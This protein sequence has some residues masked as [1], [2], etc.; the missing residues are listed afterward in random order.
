MVFESI[1]VDLL[2]RFVGEY[3]ENLDSKQLKIGIWGGDVVLENLVMKQSALDDLNLPVKTV[4]GHLGKLILKIPWKNL[5]SSPTEA[6]V[7]KLFLLVVPNQDTRYD[8]VKEEKWKQEAKQAEIEKVEAAKKKELE[9]DK[10]KADDTFTEKMITQ[11]VRNV[12]ICIKDIH[13]RYE[14]RV[15]SPKSPFSFGITLH[16]LS[17]TTTNEDWIP[18]ISQDVTGKIFKHLTIDGLAIYWNSNCELFSLIQSQGLNNK[19]QSGI[20]SKGQLVPGY[21]YMVGP[22]SC[23]AKLQL[24][25]KPELDDFQV[26]KS[27]FNIEMEKV[28]LKISKLQYRDIFALVDSLDRMRRAALYRKYRPQ[29]NTFRGHYKL[30]WQYAY[31]CIL[32][33][34]VRRRRRNWDWVHIFTHRANCRK[35]AEA[36]Q[37]KLI[38]ANKESD[39]TCKECEL[40]LDA[41]NIVLIRQKI[42]VEVERQGKL[43]EAKKKSE[44]AKGWFSGWWGGGSSESV[45]ED[46]SKTDDIKKQ[47]AEAMS[48]EEKEKLF[49]AIGYQENFVP[50]DLP[51]EFVAVRLNF[52]LQCLEVE[53]RDDDLQDEKSV[54]RVALN[55]ME[56]QLEQRPSANAI[57]VT[58][59]MYNLSA[60]GLKQLDG[61]PEVCSS[62]H[63]IEG[64]GK[65]PLV[66]IIFE[67][68]PLCGTCD[69]RVHAEFKPLQIVYDAQTIIKLT[70]IFTPQEEQSAVVSQLQAA[71]QM[72]MAE[73]KEKSALGLQ[74]TIQKHTRL[75]LKIDVMAS[76]VIIP[77]GGFY[78]KKQPILV[79]NLGKFSVSS[80]LRQEDPLNV[81]NMHKEGYSEDKILDIL[82]A[83]S[84]DHFVLKLEAAQVL[85]AYPDEDWLSL[86]CN[87]KQSDLHLLNPTDLTIEIEKCLISDDP[88]LPKVKIK[89][90]LP[91]ITLRIKEKRMVDTLV[92]LM[93]IPF[94]EAKPPKSHDQDQGIQ[95]YQSTLSITPHD[96]NR[97][98]K[99]KTVSMQVE[100]EEIIQY[101]DVE[102]N[103]ELQQIF[104]EM[105][106]EKGALS[107]NPTVSM[108]VL[109]LEA[110]LLVQTF[111][112]SAEARLGGLELLHNFESKVIKVIDTPMA[113]G[114]NEDLLILNY[115]SADKDSP[116]FH[117]RYGSILQY[118]TVHFS[119]LN[120]LV[121]QEALMFLIHWIGNTQSYIEEQ[122]KALGTKTLEARPNTLTVKKENFRSSLTNL[123]ESMR[124][125]F[126]P[127]ASRVI[128]KK[129]KAKR[130]EVIDL[131]LDAKLDEIGI[132][133]SNNMHDLARLEVSGCNSSII[134]KKSYTQI[135]GKLTNFQVFDFNKDTAHP[136][137]LTI[138]GKEE[139][140][141]AQLVLFNEELL[142]RTTD[143][144]NMSVRA[145]IGCVRIVFINRFL[146][147]VIGFMNNF[148]T[149]QEKLREASAA[150]AEAARSNVR[151]AYS[152]AVKIRL[153][154]N[155]K[156]PIIVIP[157]NSKSFNAMF[158][159]FGF[160]TISNNFQDIVTK[161]DG[162]TA[163]IDHIS[164]NLVNLKASRVLLDDQGTIKTEQNILKPIT[165]DLGVQRNLSCGWYTDV[166]DLDVG[167]RLGT[168]LIQLTQNDYVTLMSI[169]S[170]NLAE[171]DSSYTKPNEHPH[172]QPQEHPQEHISSVATVSSNVPMSKSSTSTKAL[173]QSL[174][175]GSGP[176]IPQSD[177]TTSIKFNFRLESIV[178][179]LFTDD[180]ETED[181]RRN[182]V[183]SQSL[184]R[185]TLHLL[186]VKG[187]M[188]SD[189]T[190]AS[191]VLML[192]LLL[193][194]TRASKASKINRYMERVAQD[195][196]SNE[197]KS[198]ESQIESDSLFV[199]S[200][201]TFQVD[202]RQRESS[203]TPAHRRAMVDATIR[204][205]DGNLYLDLRVYSFLLILNLEHL[206]K[207]RDLFVL[208]EKPEVFDVAKKLSNQTKLHA[209]SV[210]SYVAKVE[211]QTAQVGVEN[212]EI[213]RN[214]DIH[215]EKPDII[216]VENL[217]DVNTNALNLQ[218]EMNAKLS[219]SG[220]G[221]HQSISANIMDLQ[222]FTCC[223]NP[224][225]RQNTKSLVLFP[226]C[227]SLVGTTPEDNGLHL[228]LSTTR[229]HLSVSPGTIE[230]LNKCYQ[231]LYDEGGNSKSNRNDSDYS[232]VWN[233]SRVEEKDFWFLSSEVAQDALEVLAIES[234]VEAVEP[235]NEVCSVCVPSLVITLDTGIGKHTVPCL[236]LESTASGKV[237]NWSSNLSVNME[238]TLQIDYYNY[239]LA[240][241][242]PVLEPIETFN[243]GDRVL[244]PWK[245]NMEMKKLAVEDVQQQC[246]DDTEGKPPAMTINIKSLEAMELTITKTCLDVLSN[247][248]ASFQDAIYKPETIE[249]FEIKAPYLIQNDTGLSISVV[250]AN[251]A[252]RVSGVENTESI[253]EVVLKPD[254]SV[255]LSAL[256]LTGNE[257]V[258]R[259]SF[260]GNKETG[261]SSGRKRSP[262]LQTSFVNRM[263]IR[264]IDERFL[265]LNIEEMNG[266][267]QIPMMKCDKRYFTLHKPNSPDTV[268]SKSISSE[269]IGLVV[270]ITLESNATM[271][272][273]LCSIIRIYN[274]FSVAI[275]VYF[276]TKKGNEVQLIT[277]IPPKSHFNLPV[278][279]IYTPAKE[280]FFSVEGYSLSTNPFIWKEVQS[281]WKFSKLLQCNSKNSEDK[282][283]FFIKAV[284]E[285]EQ[286]YFEHGNRH[287]M[288]SNCININLNPPVVL[289]NLLPVDIIC[290]VQGIVAENSIKS[291]GLFEIPT[292]EPGS[293][294]I[295]L[296]ISGYLDREWSC[297][298]SI[299]E[300][301]P[302]LDVWI[303]ECYES[304]Q[305]IC[306]ELGMHSVI[307]NGC[308]VMQLYCPFW[309]INKTG[310]SL[311]YRRSGKPT[312][313]TVS[314]GIPTEQPDDMSNVLFHPDNFKG[315]VMFS[316]RAKNFFGKKKAT[317]KVENGEWSEKF[318][319]D[320]V[321]SYGVVSCV[322]NSIKYQIGVNIQ[323]MSNS[324]TKQVI[325][326]PYNVLVNNSPQTT[327]EY[328]E[329]V[330]SG[331]WKPIS[332]LSCCPFYPK[333]A[334]SSQLI[335]RVMD[336]AQ[337]T[338]SFPYDTIHNTL[339]KLDNEFG[340]VSVDVQITE[341]SVHITFDDFGPELATALIVNKTDF[342]ITLKEKNV[343]HEKIT[344]P[345][346]HKTLFCWS[347]FNEDRFITWNEEKYK[348]DLLKSDVGDFNVASNVTSYF[349]SFLDGRQ[350]ILLFTMD[351]TLVQTVQNAGQIQ[352]F[353]SEIILSIHGIGLSLVDNIKLNE[354]LYLGITSSVS[355]ESLK[356]SKKQ[357]KA[358]PEAQNELLE[359]EYQLY[360]Q[361]KRQGGNVPAV[362][363][364]GDKMI[365]FEKFMVK[366]PH[367]K[368]LNRAYRTGFWVSYKQSK[369]Q[370]QIHS[371]INRLQI[372]NQMQDCVFPVVLAPVPPPKSVAQQHAIKPFVEVSVVECLTERS[373]IKQ[374]KYFK[375]LMQEFHVKV[376]AGF[377]NSIVSFFEAGD[378]SD[379]EEQK[380]FKND[381]KSID[382]ELM[383]RVEMISSREQKNYYD[384][385]H[386]S[387]IKMHVSFSLSGGIGGSGGGVHDSLPPIVSLLTQSLGVT[388]TDMHDVVFK[389]SYFERQYIF[390]NQR[391]IM[392]EIQSHYIGQLIK[393]FYVLVFGLDV[394]GNPYGLVVGLKH[395]VEDLFYE[396]F[397]GAIQ[398]PGEFAEGLYLGVKS[399]FGHTVGG[400]AGAMSRI[401]GAMGKGL[402]ALTFDEDY[403]RK[404]REQTE[405]QCTVQESITR[406]GKGIVMGVV[407]GVGG[408][409]TKPISGAKEEGVEG[410]FKGFGK[411]MVGLVTRPT[412]GV[413]D[414]ASGTLSSVRRITQFSEE[415]MRQR[416]PRN[417][418]N[419][420]YI[421]PYSKLDAEGCKLLQE[422]DKGRYAGTDTYVYHIPI[423]NKDT[424]LL[425][426]KRIVYVTH[427]DMFG[428][429]QAEWTHTWGELSEAP[430]LADTGIILVLQD[431]KKKLFRSS[432]SKKMLVIPEEDRRRAVFAKMNSC[433]QVSSRG[434]LASGAGSISSQN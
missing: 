68:N 144:V 248:G 403:Q 128:V 101:T 327:L 390:I 190:I 280:L 299:A 75:D 186:S 139:L 87:L 79:Y 82:R 22:I 205:K 150:A 60:S 428:G 408:V 289:K 49:R 104:I 372:D 34:E 218:M 315:P 114:K 243:E 133:L 427:S 434:S 379:E 383:S 80:R 424:L 271:K 43:L 336:T 401:T 77:H 61:L 45:I 66:K 381:C 366:K 88:R 341:G 86:C 338:L 397:Q 169:V 197:T 14:D 36:Y 211:N 359:E 170:E 130:V 182:S 410:F 288:N 180:Q 167:A 409:F 191:S 382:E 85:L 157:E 1:V 179:E 405:Q 177:I 369:H 272:V 90:S 419:D 74:Y 27:L 23:T 227:V 11:I 141:T 35:Y 331:E 221:K 431:A 206:L 192:N 284:G 137:V 136:K 237:H 3:V 93:S 195:I 356:S 311:C 100:D 131:K 385:F 297:K 298:N 9:K 193:D 358:L 363:P 339:L 209:S 92:L 21:K 163:V 278:Q 313:E 57:R 357:F 406:G 417:F 266:E 76:H 348:T 244:N 295:V 253:R 5:Y 265:T 24:N 2:N 121:Q 153:N 44:K 148:Q 402:A 370:V 380:R 37:A 318:S 115:L 258:A 325:L 226:F 285:V 322:T 26:P 320:V 350:R 304:P 103:F 393:Q 246:R 395:G 207:I 335:V 18:A 112:I 261:G 413:V 125:L 164:L 32:E 329:S 126:H 29:V 134:I 302:E 384:F 387:P 204:L 199:D 433:L 220:S 245:L 420:R 25:T 314:S 16:N 154:I 317:I 360:L 39:E 283:P 173:S 235:L 391:Q 219:M 389:L 274:N 108:S 171:V 294:S 124:E 392:Y 7:E 145:D 399:L 51:V 321:G 42:E 232:N 400:A 333:S 259:T 184:A 236:F 411:G 367:E 71:Y 105:I 65:T 151:Q 155:L 249:K 109:K 72:K 203:V 95:L 158:F 287:T 201:D 50:D 83:E 273:T 234:S 48:G 178:V 81:R 146:T 260:Q 270:D 257:H 240:V 347:T 423:G 376:D 282:E 378:I 323:L 368:E 58:S 412:A 242:E 210:T 425:T 255:P 319:L 55:Q 276:M 40:A 147:S 225:K 56:L 159:D 301:P 59:M 13:I 223:Y 102:A 99:Q 165:F 119:K 292:C 328:K 343:E 12:Q 116:E 361:R 132:T 174:G 346:N 386:F 41:F 160:L 63:N 78:D 196:D 396:P 84:Y 291:G 176:K 94:T 415:V 142:Q 168:I 303:F 414:F 194:D 308:L 351:P 241:W 355:W 143:A 364:V 96:M 373:V 4:H 52:I 135:D 332:P 340:G 279:A 310:L 28:Q 231:T 262:S 15:T 239:S 67:T 53:V 264:S 374:F 344:L 149:A 6:T 334:G 388:L 33:E 429:F 375:V 162:H 189:G 69:H 277:S 129:G 152:A 305:R 17:V 432:N 230:L 62:L 426:D 296:R 228:D 371:K 326:T 111:Q 113:S 54:M 418:K 353:D 138:V 233:V 251:D 214:I 31:T 349:A 293:S 98:K 47:F 156:A 10:P 238:I 263:S 254:A 268:S 307:K 407:G 198:S 247:I 117:S 398:G 19:F 430:K 316:F 275:S 181:G 365:D 404:R 91:Q 208:P 290:C 89:G 421:R 362:V 8:P 324:L 212:K 216:L 224:E 229:I 140:M 30:W 38:S 187:V 20:P 106:A 309:M 422:V 330:H 252:F 394:L 377:I 188:L 281:N 213:M 183:L 352:Q 342:E 200:E 127:T 222:L 337:E 286:V 345:P 215:V 120:V 172:E 107:Y 217:D 161:H 202:F 110:S 416:N 306:F 70:D 166:P 73:V 175:K 354:I 250:L 118:L 267:L 122:G 64:D 256:D 269:Q 46:Q 97:L 185:M 300:E 123:Q 312:A